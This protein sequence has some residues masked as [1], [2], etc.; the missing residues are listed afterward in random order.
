MYACEGVRAVEGQMRQS[1][2]HLRRL[3]RN[4]FSIVHS[5]NRGRLRAVKLYA[6]PCS[7][8]STRPSTLANV[9]I[10]ASTCVLAVILQL[11]LA[12]PFGRPTSFEPAGRLPPLP[13]RISLP[14]HGCEG[15]LACLT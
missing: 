8:L 4:N 13:C 14:D 7:A 5:R 11:F 3:W 12:H 10:V 6:L 15:C 9:D 1:M 2:P